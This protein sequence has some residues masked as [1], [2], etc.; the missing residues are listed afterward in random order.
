MQKKMGSLARFTKKAFKLL[1][2]LTGA[3]AIGV[4]ILISINRHGH[5]VN[6]ILSI[7]YFSVLA[8]ALALVIKEKFLNKSET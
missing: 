5:E 2:Q 3:L 8:W 1:A 7:V 6:V 4:G